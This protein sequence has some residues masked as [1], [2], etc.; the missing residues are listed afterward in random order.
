MA[1]SRSRVV[2]ADLIIVATPRNLRH[3][4]WRALYAS[5]ERH[6]GSIGLGLKLL[7]RAVLDCDKMSRRSMSFVEAAVWAMCMAADFL[8]SV[9]ASLC[10]AV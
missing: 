4:M 5:G 9:H 10:L 1:L 6:L 3:G 2:A 7:Q 8:S